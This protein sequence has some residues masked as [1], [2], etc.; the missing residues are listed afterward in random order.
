MLFCD[1][2]GSTALAE[3]F[4][5]EDWA[6]IMNEAFGY[7]NDPVYRYGG[8][9]ARLMGDGIL[10][11]FGAP[12][13]H[14]DDPERAVLAGLAIVDEMQPFRDQILREYSLDFNVRV[15]INT[16]PVVVGDVGSAQAGEY[17][18]M[19]DAVNMAARME[20]TAQP[21]TVQIG[22]DTYRLVAPLFDFEPLGGIEVKGKSAPVPAYRAIRPKEHP[23]SLRGI[24]GLHSPL[25]GRD[26]EF[27]KLRQAIEEVREGR[28]Q[29]VFL[30]GD[31]GLGKSRLI[32]ELRV[33]WDQIKGDE[34]SLG[35]GSW[36][37]SRGLS[38]ESTRPYGLFMQRVREILGIEE[39]TPRE[40]IQDSIAEA[41]ASYPDDGHRET[42]TRAVESLLAIRSQSNGTGVDGEALKREMYEAVLQV[43]RQMAAQ[44]AIVMVF[45]DLHWADP[46]SVD[47]LIHLFQLVDDSPILYICAMRPER[48]SPG[49]K[50]KQAAESNYPHRYTEIGLTPLTSEESDALVDNLLHISDLPPYIHQ[51]ILEKT[52]GNPFFVEE[53]VRTLIDSGTIVQDEDGKHWHAVSDIRDIAIPDSLQALLLARIDRLEKNARYTLQLASVIGRTFY[54]HVLQVVSDAAA[55]LD[56]HLNSLQQFDLIREAA[57]VPE[58][59]YV[60]RHELTREAAYNSILRRRCRIFHRWVAEA[61]ETLYADRLQEQA[62]RLAYHFHQAGSDEPAL[63]YYAMAGD[64]AARM[65]A[66]A[67]ATMHYSSAIDIAGRIE[68]TNEQ[69]TDLHINRGWALH[70][71]GRFDEAIANYQA[72]EELG[73]EKNDLH[74]ELAA[75]IPQATIYSTFTVRFDPE[76]A[77]SLSNRTLSLAQ[78]L[79]DPRAEARALWNLM[80]VEIYS[81]SPPE[82][83]LA[84]LW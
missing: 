30:T 52:D 6:D 3:Q 76:Q 66:N 55:E 82:K 22:S 83:A 77:Y 74:M 72:L 14:E 35:H 65:Y 32:E 40:M 27:Q 49:W 33:E 61:M 39:D 11:F 4:D 28:G 25:I 50:I 62:H 21:G 79:K 23:G 68:V 47:L 7:F 31:A 63:K 60:F 42:V 45:D 8:T 78:E 48:Q 69:V 19:G 84:C 13:A 75:L 16:G 41:V 29:I 81:I 46:A 20:H 37:V 67:E 36:T 54:Y 51:L 44:E 17:T 38:Y 10:A 58:L 43:W 57:R 53:V 71:E 56:K 1:V 2:A 59:E 80:L 18:A 26:E 34:S 5:R 73:K 24:E 64:A 9:V 12:F 15:G 70:A